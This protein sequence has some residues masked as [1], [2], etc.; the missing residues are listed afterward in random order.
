M[1]TL[2]L[3]KVE[4]ISCAYLQST[5][6]QRNRIRGCFSGKVRLTA[7]HLQLIFELMF[8]FF[9]TYRAKNCRVVQSQIAVHAELQVF[10]VTLS[11]QRCLRP[12]DV[13]WVSCEKVWGYLQTRWPMD[14]P[15]YRG[16]RIFAKPRW[17]GP[18]ELRKSLC[19]WF[20]DVCSCCS[21][22]ALPGRAWVMLSHLSSAL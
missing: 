1:V 19:T 6:G 16:D 11:Y 3:T 22:T 20:G 2:A 14:Q 7:P 4:E 21:L 18:T 13:G 5:Q 12:A 17:V 10:S 9:S 15:L 8:N